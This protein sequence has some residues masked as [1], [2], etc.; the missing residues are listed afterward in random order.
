[1]SRRAHSRR[2]AATI[3]AA[4]AGEMAMA[5][6]ADLVV[7]AVAMVHLEVQIGQAIAANSTPSCEIGLEGV[8]ALLVTLAAV[9]CQRRATQLYTCACSTNAA[10]SRITGTRSS[11]AC[12]SDR[13]QLHTTGMPSRSRYLALCILPRARGS[14]TISPARHQTPTPTPASFDPVR[15]RRRR[16]GPRAAPSG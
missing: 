7:A 9:N 11:G 16:L 1:M 15:C 2:R 10:R 6:T 5:A 8:C 12:T 4:T 3:M 14:R 13:R